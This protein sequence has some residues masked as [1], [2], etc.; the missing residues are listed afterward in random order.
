MF[1]KKSNIITLKKLFLWKQKKENDEVEDKE[2]W[3]ER[4]GEGKE[5]RFAKNLERRNPTATNSDHY[6]KL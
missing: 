1:F 4:E 2:E 6:N 5:E 3:G